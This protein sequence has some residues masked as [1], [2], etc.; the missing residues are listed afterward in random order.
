M[1][2]PCDQGD[3][4][5]LPGGQCRKGFACKAPPGGRR[6]RC[7]WQDVGA[8]CGNKRCS[9]DEPV[10][11]RDP[12]KTAGHC[13]ARL[14]KRG[15]QRLACSRPRDCGGSTCG[16]NQYFGDPTAPQPGYV[17]TTLSHLVFEVL[18]DKL[19]DCPPHPPTGQKA[20]ACRRSEG[21]PRG[22]KACV[23]LDE[24]D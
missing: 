4:V 13:S 1:K 2:G 23:Y 22:V 16:R 5:C 3:E 9:G 6:G 12:D 14:C 7:Y 20:S 10:C 11:C 21:L 17:C 8:W 19:S 24:T 15:E 18:C